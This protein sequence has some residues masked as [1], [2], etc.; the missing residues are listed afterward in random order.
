MNRSP[1]V[2]AAGDALPMNLPT[3]VFSRLSVTGVARVSAVAAES[4]PG[5]VGPR[6]RLWRKQKTSVY[7]G[8]R[9]CQR[10]DTVECSTNDLYLPQ[11]TGTGNKLQRTHLT[12]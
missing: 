4:R 1:E 8:R 7:F 5:T 3:Y 2:G 9:G 10:I 11:A 12:V 6:R